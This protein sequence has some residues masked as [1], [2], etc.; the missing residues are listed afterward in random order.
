VNYT[1]AVTSDMQAISDFRELTQRMTYRIAGLPIVI[2]AQDSWAA[3]VIERLFSGW[4]LIPDSDISSGPS[5]AEIV[6]GSTVTPPEIPR[7]WPQFEIAGEGTCYTDGETS[8][9]DIE[10]SIIAI[11]RPGQSLVQVWTNGELEV[12]SSTLTRVVTYALSIALRHRGFFELHSGAVVEPQSGRGV[13][14]IGPSGS[15]KST[16][17]VQLATAGWPFLTD[18]VLV[19]SSQ[20]EAV[21][22]WPIRRSFAITSGTFEACEFLRSRISL[23]YR[24]KLYGDKSQFAPHDVFNSGFREQCVP[25]RLFFTQLSGGTRS[26]VLQLSAR[27]TMA[28]LIRM[29]PWSCYDRT[30]AKDHLATLAA[31]AK[32]SVGFSLDAGQ[33]LLDTET[34]A[35]LIARYT[36]N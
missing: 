33:D 36:R 8:Y 17:T 9:I 30:T 3:H 13:L 2:D 6:I 25:A 28:R 31:L 20:D 21:K 26:S 4:Y 29:S 18:D 19:L 5:A 32:Q 23:D 34:S 11:A 1:G 7:D 15:G 10:G 16:L 22:A 35:G 27:E 12:Q 14:I 24:E